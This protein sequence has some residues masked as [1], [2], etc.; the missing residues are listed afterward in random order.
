MLNNGRN[1][2]ASVRSRQACTNQKY[3]PYYIILLGGSWPLGGASEGPS[4]FLLKEADRSQQFTLSVPGRSAPS[5]SP[6][7]ETGG[8]MEGLHHSY[9]HCSLTGGWVFGSYLAWLRL[10]GLFPAT[11]FSPL[12]SCL[13][14]FKVLW[15]AIFGNKS[16]RDKC[17]FLYGTYQY[18]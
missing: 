16:T 7:R 12:N 8:E 10:A 14:E 9:K 5:L 4:L 15:T 2:E 11:F 3:C 13:C 18:V 1:V 17:Y 6:D